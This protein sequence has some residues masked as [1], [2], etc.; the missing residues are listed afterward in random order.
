MRL[1]DDEFREGQVVRPT[2]NWVCGRATEGPDCEDGPLPDGICGNAVSRC[3][4]IPSLLAVRRRVAFWLSMV[5]IGLSLLFLSGLNEPAFFSPGELTFGHGASA[6][7]CADCHSAA[8]GSLVDWVSALGVPGTKEENGKLCLRCH[9]L[10]E[11]AF[12]AHGRPT[13]ELAVVTERL[14]RTSGSTDV[15]FFLGVASWVPGVVPTKGEP[16]ACATCHREHR[17]KLFNLTAMDEQQCQTCHTRTFSDFANG[18]PPFSSYPYKRRT[19]IAFDHTSHIGKHFLG[20]FKKDAPVTCTA[21]HRPDDDGQTMRTGTFENVCASCHAGQI[22]GI[23]RSDAKG[24]AFLR[25]PGLDLETLQEHGVSVGEWPA[26]AN[27]EDGLTPFMKL[28]LKTDSVFT[29]D[30][31]LLSGFDDFTDL[32]DATDEEIA[33]VGRM[34]WAVKRLVYDLI[35]K[36]QPEISNRLRMTTNIGTRKF[37][38]LFGQLPVEVIYA[39]Q[40]QWLP[41]L[42]ME[43][44]DS[45]AVETVMRLE[46][47]NVE[48]EVQMDRERERRMMVGGWYRQDSEFAILY[49]PIG[50][51]DPFLCAW[52]DLTAQATGVKHVRS[53]EEIFTALANPKAPGLCMKCH[54]VDAQAGQRKRIH[55]SAARPVPHERKATRFAHDVHFSLLDD[56]GCL[57]CHMMN[58][59]AEVMESFK[60]ADPLTFTSNFRAMKKTVCATCHTSERA[61]GTCLTCHNY[62]L[63]TVSPILSKSPLTVSSP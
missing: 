36:G 23:G 32:S 4:P 41:H 18:H 17:G 15:P 45:G 62:H 63:G 46:N 57:T 11:R 21:C 61:E 1:R 20:E 47:R 58:P 13:R 5:T 27:V 54:S 28:L 9:N 33:A 22:E 19:R 6:E 49:R 59:E 48:Q 16:L 31:A 53:A 40:Q 35:M 25:L 50:H 26:D 29:E 8:H 30:L 52:L 7:A 37:T 56:K 24:L 55:W 3:Q 38:D 43:L 42:A 14:G 44:S 10:G 39:A 34:T 2:R 60:D 12:Q 51:A